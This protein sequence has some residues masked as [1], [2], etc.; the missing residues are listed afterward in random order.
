MTIQ[1]P[2]VI[3]DK[4]DLDRFD[5]CIECQGPASVSI[6][7]QIVFE[8]S[9][10][11]DCKFNYKEIVDLSINFIDVSVVCQQVDKIILNDVDLERN[12]LRYKL[13]NSH[14]YHSGKFKLH[15]PVPV[16]PGLIKM[17][18]FTEIHGNWPDADRL[19]LMS[20]NINTIKQ[21]KYNAINR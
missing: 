14:D 10:P 4:L 7:N 5:L 15:I 16:T 21:R 8:E 11:I 20:K 12:G 2:E 1:I 19:E 9:N 3:L 18:T 17:V 13:T 6:R